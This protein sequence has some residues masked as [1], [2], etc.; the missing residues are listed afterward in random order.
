MKVFNILSSLCIIPFVLSAIT[1]TEPSPSSFWVQNQT[2]TISWTFASGDPNPISIVIVNSNN[3]FL[4][5]E[6]S[7]HEFVDLSNGSFTV[8]NVTLLVAS[9]YQ[10]EFVNT[11]N[12]TQVFATSQTF[13]VKAPGTA[14]ANSS[15]TTTGSAASGTATSPSTTGSSG[16]GS[17]GSG[18]ATGSS[19]SGSSTSTSSGGSNLNGAMGLSMGL[20]MSAVM[21]SVGLGLVGM[22]FVL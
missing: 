18:S 19:T 21:G 7:I 20:S 1:I 6:Y 3:T 22:L 11:T 17:S 15:T 9:G 14:P 10:V 16:S 12:L 2:N 5:G 4:N 13:D 8:T